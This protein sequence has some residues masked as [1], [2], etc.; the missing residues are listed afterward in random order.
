MRTLNHR[1]PKVQQQVPHDVPGLTLRWCH[2][3]HLP[4]LVAQGVDDELP[5]SIAGLPATST[6]CYHLKSSRIH[7]KLLLPRQKLYAKIAQ[8]RPR[9]VSYQSS[10]SQT[11]GQISPYSPSPA[12]HSHFPPVSIPGLAFFL[13]F[14]ARTASATRSIL[15]CTPWGLPDSFSFFDIL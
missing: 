5:R 2:V 9:R 6:G 10:S 15:P 7:P 8:L 13:G 12:P 3:E 11:A 1:P 14:M 4:G